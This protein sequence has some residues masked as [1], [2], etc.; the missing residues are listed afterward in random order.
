MH[1]VTMKIIDTEEFHSLNL[2][3]Y[4]TYHQLQN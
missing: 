3:G 4:S 1:G 2:G